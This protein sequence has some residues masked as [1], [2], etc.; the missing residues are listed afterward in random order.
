M[1]K[2]TLIQLQKLL[3]HMIYYNRMAP[4]PVFDT[5]YVKEIEN[6]I[7]KMKEDKINYDNEPVLA[8]RYCNNLHIIVDD[9]DNNICFRCNSVNEIQEFK[10]IFEWEEKEKK[11]KSNIR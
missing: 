10:T 1:S 3:D 2:K 5:D 7:I 9:V 11:R 8:C 6:K 4:F